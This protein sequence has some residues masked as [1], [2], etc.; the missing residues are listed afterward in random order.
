[1]PRRPP[2][3]SPDEL[4]E[5]LENIKFAVDYLFKLSILLRKEIPPTQ[6]RRSQTGKPDQLIHAEQITTDISKVMKSSWLLQRLD[7]SIDARIQDLQHQLKQ[8]DA[9]NV[10]KPITQRTLD[11]ESGVEI[12][13]TPGGNIHLASNVQF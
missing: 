9:K 6:V 3:T 1:M 5:L 8:R 12:T 7:F 2:E 13:Y 11:S 4:Q 10:A